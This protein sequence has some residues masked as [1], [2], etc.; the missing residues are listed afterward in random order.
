MDAAYYGRSIHYGRSG[1]DGVFT[2]PKRRPMYL[3][4]LRCHVPLR[5]ESRLVPLRSG[6]C[7][8]KTVRWTDLF[9]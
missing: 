4:G 7:I 2:C 5:F 1:Q 8:E 3:L 9:G 6:R